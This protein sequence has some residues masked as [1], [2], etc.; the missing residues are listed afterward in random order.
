MYV[1]NRWHF[2]LLF[3][4]N[5]S[6]PWLVQQD[7]PTI[8]YFRHT[9]DTV[10]LNWSW[11]YTLSFHWLV[12]QYKLSFFPHRCSIWY[13]MGDILWHIMRLVVEKVEN[14]LEKVQYLIQ[15]VFLVENCWN[16]CKKNMLLFIDNKTKSQLRV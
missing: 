16:I 2:H 4:Y 11:N 13:I 7:D 14:E 12:C 6:L 3:W 8:F 1:K 9:Y 10:Y 15:D 5:L